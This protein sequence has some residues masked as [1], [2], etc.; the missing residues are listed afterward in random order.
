M[1][2]LQTSEAHLPATLA[3]DPGATERLGQAVERLRCDVLLAG[4]NAAAGQPMEAWQIAAAFVFH[5]GQVVVRR[6]QLARYFAGSDELA[7]ECLAAGWLRPIINRHRLVVFDINHIALCV[8]RVRR[9]GSP[10]TGPAPA[11]GNAKPQP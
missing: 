7:Q 6:N 9:E 3:Q 11:K 4:L 8:D 2:T 5:H 1:E 10:G